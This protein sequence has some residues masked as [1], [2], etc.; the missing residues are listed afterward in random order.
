[1]RQVGPDYE[2]YAVFGPLVDSSVAAACC[3]R[4]VRAIKKDDDALFLLQPG[5]WS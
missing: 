5:V 4:L 3:T 2:L 1:M